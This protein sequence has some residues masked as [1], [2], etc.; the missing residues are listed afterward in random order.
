MR[1]R[2]EENENVTKACTGCGKQF[3][4][5][6]KRG[7]KEFLKRKFCSLSCLHATLKRNRKQDASTRVRTINGKQYVVER[8]YTPRK[9]WDP[10]PEETKRKAAADAYRKDWQDRQR[11][12]AE[13]A[14]G[15]AATVGEYPGETVDLRLRALL[16]GKV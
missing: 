11:R 12:D 8:A 1:K 9:N 13:Y 10:N 3:G 7:F 4:H 14:R 5:D 2:N 16:P 6:Y 15:N